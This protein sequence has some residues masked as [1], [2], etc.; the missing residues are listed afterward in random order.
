MSA[1][2]V[3]PSYW[4]LKQPINSASLHP[5]PASLPN[6]CR[7]DASLKPQPPLSVLIN[8][9]WIYY[10]QWID[11]IVR[12]FSCSNNNKKKTFNDKKRSGGSTG[13]WRV[14]EASRLQQEVAW[15]TFGYKRCGLC[16]S[17]HGSPISCPT[18]VL[19]GFP[20]K[21]SM[22]RA[23]SEGPA[24]APTSPG[25]RAVCYEKPRS[26]SCCCCRRCCYCSHNKVGHQLSCV[27][28]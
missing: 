11:V 22:L 14:S 19:N 6:H 24:N 3:P 8:I 15:D 12:V 21:N 17:H 2:R 4:Q 28:L 27:T 10:F 25:S 26:S 20:S 23:V 18:G 13:G 1:A 16:R 7:A 9:S 5:S